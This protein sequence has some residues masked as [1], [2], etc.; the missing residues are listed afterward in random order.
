MEK[1][2]TKLLCLM[3]G[4]TLG[5]LL[6]ATNPLKAQ[7]DCKVVLD[8]EFKVLNTPTH[9]YGTVNIVGRTVT[10]EMIYA[11]GA[12][13]GMID[14]KWSPSGTTKDIEQLMQKNLLN[15]KI[16]CRHLKDEPVNG[17]MA[18]V[19]STHEDRPK[20]AVDS[21]VWISRAKGLPLRQEIDIDIGGSGGKSHNSM[22]YEYAN[23]K[24]PM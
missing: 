1:T 3:A 13:Y 19:Y 11:A 14:G 9:A 10:T 7:G 6:I 16:T 15:S 21:Q 23:V 4:F 8:A 18:A 22:R 5:H 2:R 20:G 12:V 24:P 17:E